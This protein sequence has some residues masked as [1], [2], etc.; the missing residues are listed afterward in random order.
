MAPFRH[1]PV[2]KH[3]PFLPSP[4]SWPKTP[5]RLTTPSSAPAKT[6]Y[7]PPT[8]RSTRHSI[9]SVSA[10]T[11]TTATA[12]G[13]GIKCA[14]NDVQGKRRQQDEQHLRRQESGVRYPMY[15]SFTGRS[16]ET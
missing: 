5:K 16:G 12:E 11:S 4:L 15:P 2:R 9:P 10:I 14:R 8:S 1:H 13:I 7:R 6:P 3:L